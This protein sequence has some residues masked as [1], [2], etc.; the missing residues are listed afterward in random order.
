MEIITPTTELEAVNL[1]LEKVL[2]ESP[3]NSLVGSTQDAAII[4][5]ILRATSRDVQREGWHFNTEECYPLLPEAPS[6]EIR[7]PLNV[8]SIRDLE[9]TQDVDDVIIWRGTR[10]YNATGRTY[11]FASTVTAT[12]IFGLDWEEL[13]DPARAYITARAG[14]EFQA[15][16]MSSQALDA[17]SKLMVEQTRVA[18]EAFE[19]D[20]AGANLL[21]KGVVAARKARRFL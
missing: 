2:G 1:I 12:L 3:V 10:L 8:I 21:S 6:G 5:N 14:R 4:S 17:F 11:S 13:P 18:L 16:A 15:G 20:N 19:I 9:Y 7:V